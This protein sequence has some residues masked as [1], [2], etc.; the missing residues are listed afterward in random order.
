MVPPERQKIAQA[1][2][3][4]LGFDPADLFNPYPLP[5]PTRR[6]S[7]S[8]S[9]SPQTRAMDAPGTPPHATSYFGKE[10]G[11]SLAG[12][13]V[14]S[15]RL[16]SLIED[17]LRPLATL[18]ESN[19]HR[20]LL[21]DTPST[22]DCH[23]LAYLALALLPSLSNPFLAT[24]FARFPS[25][26]KYTRA[27]IREAFGPPVTASDAL[28]RAPYLEEAVGDEEDGIDFESYENAKIGSGDVQ[29]PWRRAKRS[30]ASV[31]MGMARAV[32]G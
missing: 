14:T 30:A 21:S 13:A 1:R 4:H 23:A 19:S 28:I 20:Y 7:R 6:S 2:T 9:G 24:G 29:L 8:S 22:L 26:E 12:H 31:A 25:L 5:S 11:Q 18:H 32:A 10:R 17:A 15:A 27:T 3:S 16:M